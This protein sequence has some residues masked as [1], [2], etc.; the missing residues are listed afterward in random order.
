[1]GRRQ[2]LG[3]SLIGDHLDND[4]AFGHD[5]TAVEAQSG[6]LPLGI[7]LQIILT[8]FEL[9]GPDIDLD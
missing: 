9:L 2:R 7:Q 4:R 5:L 1:M 3:G 8:I 6:N